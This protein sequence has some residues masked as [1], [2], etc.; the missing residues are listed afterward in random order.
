MVLRDPKVLEFVLYMKKTNG[1]ALLYSSLWLLVYNFETP[2]AG[3]KNST[4][5]EGVL[6]LQI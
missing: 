2:S 4:R 3:D 5:H 6:P 1:F